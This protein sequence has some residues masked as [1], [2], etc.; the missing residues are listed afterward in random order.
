MCELLVFVGPEPVDPTRSLPR[1]GDVVVIMEDGHGWGAKEREYPFRIITRPGQPAESLANLL[2]NAVPH[3]AAPLYRA[4]YLDLN[5]L[6][7][8]RREPVMMEIG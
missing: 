2:G 8:C 6:E 3:G 7:K 4:F 5:T 1:S